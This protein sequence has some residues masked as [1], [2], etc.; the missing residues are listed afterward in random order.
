[1]RISNLPK[2]ETA[3]FMISSMFFISEISPPKASQIPPFLRICKAEALAK[4][5]SISFKTTFAPCEANC[6]ATSKPM[7]IP[8][9]VMMAV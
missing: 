8:A 1:M 7:P 5:L 3:N 2:V 4:S 6:L 9:P